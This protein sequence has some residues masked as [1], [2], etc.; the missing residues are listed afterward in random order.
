LV[1]KIIKF[2]QTPR[3]GYPKKYLLIEDWHE[4]NFMRKESSKHHKDNFSDMDMG[5]KTKYNVVKETLKGEPV[6]Y[7][8][9]ANFNYSDEPM[10][11]QRSYDL[12][13]LKCRKY[14]KNPCEEKP[15]GNF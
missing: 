11:C 7:L 12:F 15:T 3:E 8:I 10:N 1:K 5:E 2:S 13:L 9:D 4:G 6:W 14:L